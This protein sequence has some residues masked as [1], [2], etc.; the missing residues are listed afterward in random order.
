MIPR[1]PRGFPDPIERKLRAAQR[2]EWW[3]LFWLA[4]IVVVMY[5][6]MGNSQAMKTAWIED[7][8]SMV[9]PVVILL[10]LRLRR[11]PASARFPYG[12]H[13]AVSIAFL[14]A[15]VALAG[16]GL[17]L[18]WDGASA[19]LRREHPSIGSVEWFGVEFWEGWVMMAALAYSFVPPVILGR[20][21]LRMAPDL[22]LKPLVTDA[23]TNKADWMTALAGML[24][25]LGIGLGW[26]WADAVAAMVIALDVTRDGVRNLRNAF[27]DLLGRR[28]EKVDREDEDPL[29]A[30]V[31]AAVAAVPGVARADV[32]LREQGETLVG[33]AFFEPAPGADALALAARV[34]QAA[35]AEDWR[36]RDMVAMPVASLEALDR[37]AGRDAG[38]QGGHAEVATGAGQR[39]SV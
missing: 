25:V 3:S 35:L 29:V 16:V 27:G 30:E 8:L 15:A 21:K 9:A 31:L 22:H 7:M 34:Q 11:R 4:S 13:N 6:A 1:K 32:R 10:A 28:P 36:V 39:S 14:C 18:L 17:F 33:E 2:L 38:N 5:L 19:L 37:D 12:F 26:W 23:K 24:G 20:M